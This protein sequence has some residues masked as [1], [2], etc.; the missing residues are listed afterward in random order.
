M[1]ASIQDTL[2]TYQVKAADTLVNNFNDTS[3]F[4]HLSL[5]FGSGKTRITAK[6]IKDIVTDGGLSSVDKIFKK[7]IILAVPSLIIDE[8]KTELDAWNL[9][10]V[11]SSDFPYKGAFML[12]VP[13]YYYLDNDEC[14]SK[15]AYSKFFHGKDVVLI[16]NDELSEFIKLQHPHLNMKNKLETSATF[17]TLIWDDFDTCDAYN[18]DS[19]VKNKINM[20]DQV[21]GISTTAK[22]ENIKSKLEFTQ[23]YYEVNDVNLDRKSFCEFDFK[24]QDFYYKINLVI[25]EVFRNTDFYDEFKNGNYADAI[26]RIGVANVSSIKDLI[27]HSVRTLTDKIKDIRKEIE[28]LNE[29]TSTE[30]YE[31]QIEELNTKIKYITDRVKANMEYCSICYDDFAETSEEA[32]IICDQC[33]VCYHTKCIFEWYNSS[34]GHPMCPCCKKIVVRDSMIRMEL[35]KEEPKEAPKD[36]PKFVHATQAGAIVDALKEIKSDH[37][38]GDKLS[39]LMVSDTFKNTNVDLLNDIIPDL[40][41]ADIYEHRGNHSD[42]CKLISDFRKGVINVINIASMS[43]VAGLHLPETTHILITADVKSDAKLEQVIA[44]GQRPG[45][46]VPLKVYNLIADKN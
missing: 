39:L 1:F 33:Q 10:Y 9:K 43:D 44:R 29:V 13:D 36:E 2:Y 31:A 32:P 12:N 26:D 42:L 15:M 20:F 30:P 21:I 38:T 45:R 11:V 34:H 17:S 46:T 4:Q 27:E 18:K 37:T 16:T 3:K 35:P 40:K 14:Q 23:E 25:A 28:H 6:F 24:Q 22:K 7:R 19:D 5:P 8:W 41:I